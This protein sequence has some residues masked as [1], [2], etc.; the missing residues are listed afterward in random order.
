MLHGRVTTDGGLSLIG[1]DCFF[2]EGALAA[3][4]IILIVAW[5]TALFETHVYA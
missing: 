5:V 4:F 1:V 3:P 2:A